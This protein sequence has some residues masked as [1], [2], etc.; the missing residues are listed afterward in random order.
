MRNVEVS[1]FDLVSRIGNA[2]KEGSVS[3]RKYSR[4]V[5]FQVTNGC[6]LNCSYCY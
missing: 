4:C 6:N 2:V 3:T 5:T 1:Y